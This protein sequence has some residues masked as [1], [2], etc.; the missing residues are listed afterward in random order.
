MLVLAVEI[1][2]KIASIVEMRTFDLLFSLSSTCAYAW[3]LY[4][5]SICQELGKLLV[6]LRYL[7][8]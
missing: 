2:L 6:R 3:L 8:A 5:S 1:R 4:L 7:P